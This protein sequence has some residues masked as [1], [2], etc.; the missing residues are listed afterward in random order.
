[1][2]KQILDEIAAEPGTKAKMAILEKYKNNKTLEKVMYLAKSKRIKFYIKQI[3]EYTS[4]NFNGSLEAAMVDL[5]KI[6]KREV[7]GHDASNYLKT[8][9]THLSLDD[10]Y[11]IERIIDK[12]LKIGMGTTN[13][14][15]VIASLIEKTP[16][17]GAIPYNKEK[18]IK[19]LAKGKCKSQLKADGRYQ[20]GI[21]RSGDVSL[22]TRAGE[23]SVFEGAQFLKE[24]STLTDEHVLNGELII[25]GIPKRRVA[26]GILS[27]LDDILSKQGERTEKEHQKHLQKF[28][29]DHTSDF[30]VESITIQEILDRIIYVCWD[31][32]TVDEYYAKESDV[33]YEDRFN[34]LA[35][36]IEDAKPTRIQLIES[37]DITTFEEAMAHFSE[38]L[39]KDLEGTIVKDAYGKWKNGKPTYQI[40]LKLEINI[41][42]KIVGFQYGDVGTKNEHVIST[43]LLES[44]CGKL[45]TNPS[46]MDEKLMKDITERQDELLGTIVEIR[47][48]GLSQDKHGNWS[49]A[50]PSVE[51]LR[52]DKDTCD[53]LES[54]QKIEE[55]AKNM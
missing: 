11:V 17:M 24:L 4:N 34:K 52:P 32:I 7:T 38:V 43:L 6:Y 33:P 46:G 22:E 14:N 9:L 48:C 44:S 3:P 42:L 28:F 31:I 23:D 50:H 36:L 30:G 40:K 19:L 41:D 29:D 5:E 39:A 10:A 12:D 16:Y 45:K 26:N 1:M 51:E 13:I 18:L 27:S 54:A 53:S 25:E 49:T 21:V 37:R 35:K 2:I 15:K 20:N 55:A 47:C 8:I